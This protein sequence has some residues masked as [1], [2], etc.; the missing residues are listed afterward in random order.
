MMTQPFTSTAACQGIKQP[1]VLS[2][3]PQNL[4]FAFPF[5]GINSCGQTKPR[6]KQPV[7]PIIYESYYFHCINLLFFLF[8]ILCILEAFFTASSIY[9]RQ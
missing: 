1:K 3:I 5:M 7:Q 9:E 8:Q 6:P 2:E 4:D